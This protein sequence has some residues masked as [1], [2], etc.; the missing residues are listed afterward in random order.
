MI[1]PVDI[2]D[3][4]WHKMSY[5]TTASDMANKITAKLSIDDLEMCNQL[6]AKD[7]VDYKS[8]FQSGKLSIYM[9]DSTKTIYDLSIKAA[10][11]VVVELPDYDFE[12]GV[13]DKSFKYLNGTSVTI[14][15]STVKA[16][17]TD[18]F[19]L[20]Q[21]VKMNS[22]V[23]F[24]AKFTIKPEYTPNGWEMVL[25]L[26]DNAVGTHF[27]A[28]GSKSINLELTPYD[29]ATGGLINACNKNTDSPFN[30]ADDSF[31]TGKTLLDGQ[32]HLYSYK[33]FPLED[34]SMQIILMVDGEKFVDK[35]IYV[36]DIDFEDFFTE[37]KLSFYSKGNYDIQL[38][39]APSD[40][41]EITNGSEVTS[42]PVPTAQAT[43][44][45]TAT[46]SDT[47]DS[48]SP[49]TSDTNII[50]ITL[51][52]LMMSGTAVLGLRKKRF[53]KEQDTL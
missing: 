38:M 39:A 31:E 3:G 52:M 40:T 12:Q 17:Q 47:D 18:F 6:I 13:S 2:F 4:Q 45:P 50:F 16:G 9:N 30:E 28:D 22:T 23:S 42:T 34:G 1:S 41:P 43:I 24:K 8:I 33:V 10:P 7:G 32:W 5:Q 44:S 26:I 29:D 46:V 37:G 49:G 53:M 48:T 21:K 35:I 14:D 51:I 25:N 15:G 27:W 20:N 36:K 11:A 19:Y